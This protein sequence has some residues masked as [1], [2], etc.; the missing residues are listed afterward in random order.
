MSEIGTNGKLDIEAAEKLEKKFDTALATRDNG[1]V[2]SRVLYAA[3]IVFALYHIWTAGFGTPVEHV[4]MG[5]HLTGLFILIF[6]GFPMIRTQR[7]LEYRPSS[8]L[9]WGN[10]PAY[11]WAFATVGVMAS[12]FLAVSWVGLDVFGIIADGRGIYQPDLINPIG[13]ELLGQ[14][15]DAVSQQYGADGFIQVIFKRSRRPDYLQHHGS[16]PAVAMFR[17]QADAAE[18]CNVFALESLAVDLDG[19]EITG[20]HAGAAKGAFFVYLGYPVNDVN[21]II[22]TYFFAEAAGGTIISNY[23]NSLHFLIFSCFCQVQSRPVSIQQSARPPPH[24][25]LP[26]K[27][28]PC[29]T[30]EA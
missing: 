16:Q 21:G 7:A 4:H 22:G 27:A 28:C 13:D 15:P 6:A 1:P 17:I 12:L 9:S 25:F 30:G 18:G 14:V 20:V 26:K 10:I 3:A 2:L 29:S 23:F 19:I 11:D 5:I 24:F 8:L